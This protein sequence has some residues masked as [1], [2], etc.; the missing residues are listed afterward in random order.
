[1][2]HTTFRRLFYGSFAIGMISLL[3]LIPIL[4]ITQSLIPVYILLG[5]TGIS[6]LVTIV[7]LIIATYEKINLV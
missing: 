4:I 3:L 5:I 6:M 7:S 1:M 2:K